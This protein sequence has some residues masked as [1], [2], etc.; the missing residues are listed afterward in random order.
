MIP[1]TDLWHSVFYTQDGYVAILDLTGWRPSTDVY[2][3]DGEWVGN[4]GASNEL[5]R[6]AD[7]KHIIKWN[8]KHKQL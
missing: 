1:D 8:L 3:P 6:L 2:A 5:T 4:S 7:V